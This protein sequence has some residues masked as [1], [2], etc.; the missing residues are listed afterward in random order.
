V[1]HDLRNP[2]NAVLLGAHLLRAGELSASHARTAARITSSAER[3]T[4]LVAD[5]L[6]FTQARLGGGLRVVTQPIELHS[7]V[8][9]CVEEVRISWPGRMI[10]VRT[11]GTG[12]GRAD[13]DRLAQVVGNLTSNA[14]TYGT[15]E[16]P[17]VI[18]SSVTDESLELRVS[19][20]GRP[21][22]GELLQHIFE[23]LRRG[24][25]SVKLG[26]R[27][28]GLGLYIVREIASA[29]GGRVTVTSTE[30]EGTTFVVQLPRAEGAT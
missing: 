20:H 26:S 1:S 13:P 29:H 9:E 14:L 23:P 28:I 3:A 21:I 25:H 12:S 15:T 6:D 27:S 7:L 18:T 17:V 4:R 10:E 19:N 22:A 8:A 16:Q 2:L 5:L 11:Q 24:E 30:A